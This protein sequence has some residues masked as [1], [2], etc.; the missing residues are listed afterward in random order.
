MKDPAQTVRQ[1]L[2]L[3]C[4]DCEDGILEV[5]APNCCEHGSNYRSTCSGYFTHDMIDAAVAGIV[6]LDRSAI[7][8][9]IYVTLNPVEPALLA[10]AV[11]RIKSRARETTTDKDIL[12][13]RWLLIDIDPVRPAGV[14]ATDDELALALERARAVAEHLT[15]V[16]WPSPILA[17]S[18][19]GYHLL[20]RINLPADDGGLVK[21][22]LAALAEQFSDAVVA[23]DRSVHNPARIVKVIGTMVTSASAAKLR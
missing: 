8:P 13:R 22:V 20:Y 18:G 21:A 16:G 1:F 3:I 9:G 2:E 12:R 19:N 11:N 5:R 23:V 17:M 10:R 14:S 15:S 6:E 7:A 4:S